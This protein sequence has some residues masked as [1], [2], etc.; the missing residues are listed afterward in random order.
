MLSIIPINTSLDVKIESPILTLISIPIS[1]WA[2]L[3]DFPFH[4]KKPSP[5]ATLFFLTTAYKLVF[6]CNK[7]VTSLKYLLILLTTPIALV[8]YLLAGLFE[9]HE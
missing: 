7:V 3:V 2:Y 8:H 9:F 6:K 1:N 4:V 5:N